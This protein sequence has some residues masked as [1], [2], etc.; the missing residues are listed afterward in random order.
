MTVLRTRLDLRSD[1]FEENRA[2]MLEQL[3]VVRDLEAVEVRRASPIE[4][5]SPR[6]VSGDGDRGDT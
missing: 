3:Q 1:P 5:R 2:S 4:A 6:A